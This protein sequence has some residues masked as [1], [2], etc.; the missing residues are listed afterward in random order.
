MMKR[1]LVTGG[2]VFVSRFVARYFADRG[3]EVY[4]LN[5]GTRPQEP[6]VTLL[7]GD[8]NDLGDLLKGYYF[9]AVLD[10]T[11]YTRQDVENLLKGLGQFGDYILVSSSA[12]Y[13]EAN[14][15]PF[16]EAQTC[17]PNGIWGAY[18]IHK[19]EAENYLQE[20]VPGAYILRPPYLYGPMENI[21]RE[22]FVFECAEA[23]RKFYIPGE[24]NMKL[25]FFHVEDLCRFMEILL[26]QHPVQKIYN[27]GNPDPVSISDW[28]KLCYDVVGASLETV[29]VQGHPQRNYFCFHDYEYM[30][31]VSAQMT[32][33]GSVKPL[34][35]GLRESW[36]WFRENRQAVLRR[37]YQAYIDSNL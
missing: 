17:G 16:S 29:S 7:R 20:Q 11:A 13:P 15:Q 36:E 5:R 22:P 30:L 33:L 2:T 26:Q 4:V 3:N 6:G 14:P 25:Q 32:L 1:I 37:P 23:R 10:V 34:E 12:V 8:R 21:Y 31:D 35:M 27:V 9:D 28:V 18:G 24:G 19:L